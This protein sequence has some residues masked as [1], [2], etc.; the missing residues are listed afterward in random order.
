MIFD[1]GSRKAARLAKKHYKKT[2][3]GVFAPLR[4][5]QLFTQ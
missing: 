1:L 4:E 3:L 5:A 2:A